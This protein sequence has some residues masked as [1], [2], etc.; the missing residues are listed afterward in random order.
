MDGDEGSIDGNERNEWKD[1]LMNEHEYM[2]FKP[3][4]F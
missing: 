3:R 2:P 4:A 1:G